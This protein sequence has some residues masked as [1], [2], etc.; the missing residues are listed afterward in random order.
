MIDPQR[1][2]CSQLLPFNPILHESRALKEIYYAQLSSYIKSAG[3]GKRKWIKSELK[4]YH[5]I[6]QAAEQQTWQDI[7]NIDYRWAL[8]IDIAAILG[9]DSDLLLSSGM[10]HILSLMEK[11]LSMEQKEFARFLVGAM[12]GREDCWQRAAQS[13]FLEEIEEYIKLARKNLLF[14]RNTPYQILVTATMSAGKSTFINSLIGKNINLA[15]N[16]ACTSKIHSIIS[17][18]YEDNLIYEDDYH[19]NLN[20]DAESL[21]QDNEKNKTSHIA[22]ASHYAGA[23]GGIRL[24]IHDSPGINSSVNVEHRKVTERM[25]RTGAYN[26]LIYIINVTQKGINDD[27]TYLDFIKEY[28]GKRN[29]LF[30]ANKIDCINPD[31]EDV[32]E[33]LLSV[34][35]YLENHGFHDPMLAPFSSGAATLV[36]KKYRDGKLNHYSQWQLENLIYKFKVFDLSSYYQ[37][38]FP[39]IDIPD[40]SEDDEQLLKTC[41]LRYVEKLILNLYL[42]VI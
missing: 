4:L 8:L 10:N 22:V 13:P 24:V 30:L 29:I 16:L 19:L 20:A 27:A 36:Q 5:E 18:L 12:A 38:A 15:Q 34:K 1:M 26:L 39:Y 35:K 28:H 14:M 32:H 11:D 33:Q 6:L 37:K 42:G 17:K 40:A 31:E 9:Y 25:I 3:W 2:A 41:G 7:H 21:M 23:L